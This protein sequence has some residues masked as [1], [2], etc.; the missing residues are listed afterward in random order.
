[1]KRQNNHFKETFEAVTIS[2]NHRRSHG[3]GKGAMPPKHF[4]TYSHFVLWEAFFQTNQCYSPKIKYF[5][6][7]QILGLA[8]PLA[9]IHFV[10]CVFSGCRQTQQVKPTLKNRLGLEKMGRAFFSYILEIYQTCNKKLIF[11]EGIHGE[12]FVVRSVIC[13]NVLGALNNSK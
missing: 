4:R 5:S 7:A 3:G 8:T 9:G 2:R 10:H 1:M 12:S 13:R 11:S 6:P